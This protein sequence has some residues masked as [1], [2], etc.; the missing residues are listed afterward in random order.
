M[1]KENKRRVLNNCIIM[2][3]AIIAIILRIFGILSIPMTLPL[4]FIFLKIENMVNWSW[5]WLIPIVLI[6]M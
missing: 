6:V 4:V 5:W 2:T 1:T 3:V